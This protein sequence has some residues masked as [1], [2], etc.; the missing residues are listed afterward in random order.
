MDEDRDSE[1]PEQDILDT[2][3]AAVVSF[4][5]N[6]AEEASRNFKIHVAET[7]KSHQ[8]RADDLIERVRKAA[9]DLFDI[10]YRASDTS[11]A[12]ETKSRPYWVLRKQVPS[13]PIVIPEEDLDKLLAKLVTKLHSK[14]QSKFLNKLLPENM[15]KNRKKDRLYRQIDT[16]VN[17][18]VE[19][20]RWATLQNVKD[21]F[22][23]FGLALDQRFEEIIAATHGAIQAAYVKRKEHSEAIAAEVSRI[24]TATKELARI[25]ARFRN[26]HKRIEIL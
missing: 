21:A 3:A 15:V 19:N 23:R 26:D 18:N 14:Y 17:H 7:L 10:S 20:L 9:A 24:E 8:Q 2:M 16:L 25:C 12:F 13:L 11:E 22:Q 1:T 6:A 4:F 5:Q